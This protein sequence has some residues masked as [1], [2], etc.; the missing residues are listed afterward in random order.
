MMINIIKNF[1]QTVSLDPSR[2][3]IPK[4][5]LTENAFTNGL[6]LF[7]GLAAAVAVLIIAIS[8]LKLTISQGDPSGV[9]KA[10]DSVIY[11]CI[12]LAITLS[13]FAIVTFVIERI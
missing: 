10:R 12:G 3:N 7:F 6:Q 9:K 2:V 4:D 11:A 8:A 5:P 13:G 1:A